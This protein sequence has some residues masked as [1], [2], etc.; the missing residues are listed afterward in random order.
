M[1]KYKNFN[2]KQNKSFLHIKVQKAKVNVTT[3]IDVIVRNIIT[4]VLPEFVVVYIKIPTADTLR[5]NMHSKK[6][7]DIDR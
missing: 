6:T 2:S 4:A 5:Q 1:K 7:A 3:T